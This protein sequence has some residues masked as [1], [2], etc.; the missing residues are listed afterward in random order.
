MRGELLGRSGERQELGLVVGGQWFD[1]VDAVFAGGER[2]CLVPDDE[3]NSRH[4]FEHSGVADENA[5]KGR[6]AR[7]DADDDRCR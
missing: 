6:H 1:P 2:A 5:A 7:C 3:I 4:G